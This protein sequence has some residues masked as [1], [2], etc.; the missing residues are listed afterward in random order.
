MSYSLEF[1]ESALK[2]WH[3]LAPTIRE[4]FKDRLTERLERPHVP[5]ARLSGLPDCYKIKL[6]AAGYRLVY[7]VSDKR[8]VV[9]VIAVGKRD[10]GLV[11]LA[12]KNRT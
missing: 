1:V 5:A 4:Q 2:E 9:T 12:A 8:V 10:K 6:H 3:K 7:Q 11:Y